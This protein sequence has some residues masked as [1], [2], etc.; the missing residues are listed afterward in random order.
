M[1]YSVLLNESLDA[2][3][4]Q[5]DGIYI[6]ATFG[7][8][9]HSQ[10]I[11]EKLNTGQLFAFDRDLEAIE[12]GKD[13]F[14]DYIQNRKLILIHAPFS[15]MKTVIDAHGLTGKIN[16]ILLDLGVSSPQLDQAERGF[17]F[18][19]DG[20]LDM[21]MDQTNGVSAF[22][23]LNS[24]SVE[25]LSLIFREFGEERHAFRI[26]QAIK[27]ALQSGGDL[28]RTLKLASLIE[29]TIGKREKKHPATRCFQALRI[30]VNQE[31][32]EI[33]KT[34]IDAFELLKSTGR[35][36]VIS[37][38][39]LEDRIVKHFMTNLIKHEN[40]NLPR[41]FP[42]FDNFIPQA[43]WIIKQGKSNEDELSKNVRSRSAILRV[44]EKIKK[45]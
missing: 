15:T 24:H 14:S 3:D 30:Y 18:M 2:L 8:G 40:K 25:E 9:G 16:G 6:D 7:R 34:L 33:S 32:N 20:P 5:Q 19:K 41:G 29:K 10:A 11:L 23:V 35:L 42:V 17:S 4:I 1:H 21:R 43:K 12:Y 28:T 26:A 31:L 22:D 27:T 36:A 38:H 39:S 44:I 45:V 13:N 37:F